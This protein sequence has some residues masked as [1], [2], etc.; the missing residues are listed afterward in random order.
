LTD[1]LGKGSASI[2]RIRQPKEGASRTQSPYGLHRKENL[3]FLT[4][5]EPFVEQSLPSI[6]FTF[7]N[8]VQNQQAGQNHNVQGGNKASERVEQLKYLGTTLTNHNI[9]EQIEVRECLLALGAESFVFQFDVQKY[10]GMQKSNFVCC[11]TRV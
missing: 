2:L 10:E 8:H 1:I 5:M 9:Y 7:L 3:L 6:D 4:G 11:F